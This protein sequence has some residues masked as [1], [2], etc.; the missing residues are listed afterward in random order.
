MAVMGTYCKAYP[1]SRLREYPGWSERPGSLA[2]DALAAATDPDTA[3]GPPE[4]L[5]VQE[6]LVVTNGVYKD[7]SIVFDAVTPEWQTFC[8]DVLEFEVPPYEV[9]EFASEPT[10][11]APA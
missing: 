4:Y 1:I 8:R 11:G 3:Q 2:I 7:E 5:F 6:N 9:K 10:D